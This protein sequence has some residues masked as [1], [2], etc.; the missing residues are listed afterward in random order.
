ME[1]ERNR[2]VLPRP[3]SSEIFRSFNQNFEGLCFFTM[4][5]VSICIALV[6]I[7]AV[8][9]G[10]DAGTCA[11]D[12]T[13]Q[14]DGAAKQPSSAARAAARVAKGS[15]ERGAPPQASLRECRDRYEVCKDYA[16]QGECTKNPGWMTVSCAKSC[17]HC[18]LLDPKVRCSRAHLNISDDPIY[19][20][21]DMDH[22][23]REI[24]PRFSHTY[25][26]EVV[27]ESPWVVVFNNFL[28]DDESNAF[29]ETVDGTWERS[30][31]SGSTNELGET[32]RMISQSR[33]SS[34]AWCRYNCESDPRVQSVIRK[35]EEVTNIPYG[36]S[37]SFQILRYEPG[38]FYRVHHDMGP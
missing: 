2:N 27:S 4:R 33:T 20:P 28:T 29:I 32:G 19:H 15:N 14:N 38:Q 35:I 21:G 17:N 13:C 26:I 8:A 6:A 7:C 1:T 23:F 36:H 18:H 9:F 24:L 11:N 31:D 10:E 25:D 34:N 12:G 37:E 3:A 5:F 30:T 16:A 22:M